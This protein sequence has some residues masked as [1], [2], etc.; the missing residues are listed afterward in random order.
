MWMSTGQLVH[1]LVI[2]SRVD[3]F[4]T[5]TVGPLVSDRFTGGCL[6]DSW[7]TG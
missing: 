5:V 4:R 3:V 2:G 7:S 1:W 6:H